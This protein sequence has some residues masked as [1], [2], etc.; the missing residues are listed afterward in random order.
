MSA[1]VGTETD[2]PHTHT[3]ARRITA[4]A[5]PPTHQCD[6]STPEIQ[7]QALSLPDHLQCHEV[8]HGR[9]IGKVT[10]QYPLLPP[11]AAPP[12]PAS[13]TPLPRC[14]GNGLV[15]RLRSAIR[16][17]AHAAQRQQHVPRPQDPRAGATRV[18]AS[19]QDTLRVGGCRG[20]RCLK[21]Q[22]WFR[23]LGINHSRGEVFIMGRISMS[24]CRMPS[25]S[26]QPP[27]Y[28]SS[29]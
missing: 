12:P 24:H 21:V 11:P 28:Q 29:P 8:S 1:H 17:D 20:V 7:I 16:A 5:P 6:A 2:T 27:L 3:Q 13:S 26:P 9:H 23:D 25:S 22:G 4:S 19:H 15:V 10:E 18:D 14:R